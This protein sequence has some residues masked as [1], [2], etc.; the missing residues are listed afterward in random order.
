MPWS[1]RLRFGYSALMVAV[2][3]VTWVVCSRKYPSAKSRN[4]KRKRIL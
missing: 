2:A 4:R 1:D 3:V